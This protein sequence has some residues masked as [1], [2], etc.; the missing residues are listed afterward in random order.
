MTL[1]R[2]LGVV[3]LVCIVIANMV[4]AGVFTTSGFSLQA[5]GSPQRVLLA[6]SIAAAVAVCGAV[7]YGEL[8]RRMP[9]S[10]G[11][12]LYLTQRLH[13]FAGFLSGWVSLTAGF[14]GAIALSGLTLAEY[15][16]PLLTSAGTTSADATAAA[17]AI[18]PLTLRA[19]I[20]VSVIVG[21]GLGHSFLQRPA[22]LAQN[23]VVGLK[24]VATALF[25]L[26]AFQSAVRRSWFWAALPE[27]QQAGLPLAQTL[28]TSVMWIS[29]SFAGFN[30]AIYVASEA[31]D[32]RRQVPRAL[33]TGTLIVAV[34]Y[35]LLNLVFVTAAPVQDLSGN[36]QIAAIAAKAIGGWQLETLIRATIVVATL[37]SVAVMIMAGPRVYARMADDGVFFRYFSAGGGEIHRAV[38]LQTALAAALACMSTIR[39]LL[40]YLGATLA[41]SSAAS[42]STL[43][44]RRDSKQHT[45]AAPADDDGESRW[46][47]LPCSLVY[48]LS[49]IVFVVLMTIDDPRHLYGTVATLVAGVLLWLPVRNIAVEQQTGPAAQLQES[50]HE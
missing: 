18:D 12:Y 38:L 16:L 49:T 21:C 3:T 30:A 32:A 22:A 17:A 23:A 43:F 24:L 47:V 1:P 8:A 28:A 9:H 7:A 34:L 46:W 19:I 45:A 39:D 31:P 4:G 50:K 41:L 13:P 26:F 42:V 48:V 2:G 40:S 20:A 33:I 29:F 36:P 44:M 6:W 5:L 15:L 25:L 37:S 14:S 35:L 27:A 11:E 10:G